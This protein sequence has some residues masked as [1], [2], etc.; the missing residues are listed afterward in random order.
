ME[1]RKAATP[2]VTAGMVGTNPPSKKRDV[3]QV[4]ITLET[5][6]HRR[7]GSKDEVGNLKI[8]PKTATY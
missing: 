4:L 5:R 1:P 2:K 3:L 8:T 7:N 6:L